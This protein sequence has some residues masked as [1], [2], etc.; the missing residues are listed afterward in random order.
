M[1]FSDEAMI[2]DTEP[3]VNHLKV[4]VMYSNTIDENYSIDTNSNS[5]VF[6]IDFDDQILKDFI[7]YA[8]NSLHNN[9]VNDDDEVVNHIF[10]YI[11]NKIV[12]VSLNFAWR[13]SKC[14][15]I[16]D[17]VIKISW[18]IEQGYGNCLVRALLFKILGDSFKLKRKLHSE[19]P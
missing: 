10:R 3:I 13:H 16:L 6:L 8:V 4:P 11:S 18:F 17:N 15:T 14:P 7:Y 5:I 12:H 9:L 2:P 19:N 1:Y